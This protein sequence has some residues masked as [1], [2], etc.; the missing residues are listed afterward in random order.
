[1]KNIVVNK[2]DPVGERAVES[3]EI[4]IEAQ[5]PHAEALAEAARVYNCDAEMLE[6]AVHESLPGGTYDR[7]LGMM[8]ERKASH[9]AVAHFA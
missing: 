8:L 2:A 1:M 7:L 4:R 5:L 3:M 9:F 6:T